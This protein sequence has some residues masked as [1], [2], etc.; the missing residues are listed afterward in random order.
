MPPK[1]PT[2]SSFGGKDGSPGNDP[3]KGKPGPGRHPKSL[4]LFLKEL[5]KSAAA[6]QALQRAAADEN[7]R[8][9]STAWKY[10]ADYDDAK[11]AAKK[12]L[13]GKVEVTVKFA[14]EG[15]KNTAG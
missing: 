2:S 6:Q 11:P 14:R 15:K 9:F 3:R 1:G 12:E 4:V 7:S 13:S 5:R 10:L 8:G